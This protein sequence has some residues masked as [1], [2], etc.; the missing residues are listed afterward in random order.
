M[1]RIWELDEKTNMSEKNFMYHINN[2]IS[3]GYVIEMKAIVNYY[4]L[5]QETKNNI[6]FETV[7]KEY[8]EIENKTLVDDN[9]KDLKHNRKQICFQ[10]V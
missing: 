1:N 8:I 4:N 3:F 5:L 7:L 6:N 10:V 2:G 9:S